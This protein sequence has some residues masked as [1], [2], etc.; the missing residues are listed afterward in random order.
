MSLRINIGSVTPEVYTIMEQFDN[1]VTAVNLDPKLK[2]LVRIRVSQINGCVLCLNMHT[3]DARKLGETDQ[4]VYC[5][6]AS[7]KA[8]YYTD[9]EKA[10]LE[11]TEAVTRISESGVPDELYNRV[12]LFFSEEEYINLVVLINQINAWNRLSIA[13]NMPAED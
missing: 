10:A 11:L 5:L 6:T 2:E 4:R 8:P 9:A 13:M 7:H 12:R 3:K 1:Y